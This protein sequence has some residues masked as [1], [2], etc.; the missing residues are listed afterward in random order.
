MNAKRD[1]FL[2]QF[3]DETELEEFKKDFIERYAWGL[4]YPD[5][6]DPL[7]HAIEGIQDEWE[8]NPAPTGKDVEVWLE[9]EE[10]VRY[11]KVK[12][13]HALRKENALQAFRDQRVSGGTFM[14]AVKAANVEPSYMAYAL[15]ASNDYEINGEHLEI[16]RQARKEEYRLKAFKTRQKAYRLISSKVEAAM[17]EAD[18]SKVAPE[19]LVDMMLKLAEITKEDEQP[20]TVLRIGSFRDV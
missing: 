14:Q 7:Q 3:D 2:E 8:M 11:A 10:A 1:A 6:E 4:V 12:A 20:E 9:D 17:K 18:F 19:K 15:S 5:V 16:L 13:E